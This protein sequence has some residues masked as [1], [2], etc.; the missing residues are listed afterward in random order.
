MR[1]TNAADHEYSFGADC[2][3]PICSARACR[4]YESRCMRRLKTTSFGWRTPAVVVICGCL[5][6]MIS[7]GP[8]SS[9]GFFLT[10]LSQSNHWGR[11]VFA[12]AVAIQNL[13]WGIGQPFAGANRRPLRY[14]PRAVRWRPSLCAWPGD[15]GPL[16][17]V[18]KMLEP[19]CRRA[20]RPWAVRLFVHY[21]AWALSA[22]CCR[23]NGARLRSVPAPPLA[24]LGN[25]SFRRSPSRLMDR[26][27][28]QEALV[29]FGGVMLL[30][31]P[32]SLALATLDGAARRQASV[33]ADSNRCDKRFAEAFGHRSYVL[34]VLGFFTCGFQLAFITVHLPSYLI[35]RGLSADIGGWTLAAIGLF[36]IIGSLGAGWLSNRMPKR[37]LLSMHLFCA[38]PWRLSP[39]SRC[40]SSPPRRMVFGAVMGLLVA[41]DRAA[42]LGAGRSHVRHA[43]AGDALWLC[44]FQ[45]SGR[46][47]PWR[48]ARRHRVR[49]YRLL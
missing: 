12:F 16:D 31:L 10:P 6:A 18:R 33:A 11:D 28:W 8:R 37:Y 32:L 9:L 46:R 2:G 34:L 39:S 30:I 49:A 20:D 15:D 14:N 22:S 29:I 24:R 19:V 47:L 43:L 3:R 44:L 7:F 26:F 23:K 38:A 40:R 17:H 21:R 4:S 36:N 41:V 1:G 42:D 5:I 25:S 27:G 13:L 35:D 48:L 45:P